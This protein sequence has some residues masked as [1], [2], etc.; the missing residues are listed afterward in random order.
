MNIQAYPGLTVILR[1][2]SYEEAMFVISVLA[3]FDGKTAVEVTTNNPDY[4]Q[5]IQDGNKRYGEKILVGA[6]TVLNEKHAAKVIEHG[7]KFMLGPKM[8]DR[9]IFELAKEKN[10][11]TIPAAMTPS[12]IYQMFEEGA[13]IVKV[14][15]ATAIGSSF[16]SQLRGPFGSLPLMAVGGVRT[17][18]AKEFILAGAK[19]LGVGASMFK[20]TDI[21]SLNEAGLRAAVQKFLNIFQEVGD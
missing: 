16:F 4:L 9:K 8:F 2:Y 7:A 15:P 1:G 11:L 18:N 17:E 13:D 5:I 6:G 14:F 10:V 3:Q 21:D 19:H 12:E 20:K